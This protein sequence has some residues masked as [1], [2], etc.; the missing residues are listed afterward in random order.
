MFI[1]TWKCIQHIVWWTLVYISLNRLI[2]VSSWTSSTIDNIF[3]HAHFPYF[4]TSWFLTNTFMI[5][6][7]IPIFEEN[8]YKIFILPFDYNNHRCL[9]LL[10]AIATRSIRGLKYLLNIDRFY[11][12]S[13]N[14][15]LLVSFQTHFRIASC[16][17]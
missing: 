9:C 14:T 13:Y 8:T 15:V 6:M 17:T 3:L 10:E 1:A 12:G 11:I 2:N 5:I 16:L 4:L 7:Q